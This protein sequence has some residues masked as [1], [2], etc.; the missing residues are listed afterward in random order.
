MGSKT[1]M[2]INLI[3]LFL[4]ILRPIS[5]ASNSVVNAKID[6]K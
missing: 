2:Y 1:A 6:N 3:K 5:F 4:S